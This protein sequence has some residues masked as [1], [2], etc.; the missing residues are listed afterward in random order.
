MRENFPNFVKD[1]DTQVQEVHKVPIMIDAERPAPK[2]IIKMSKVKD[3]E[4][5]LKTAR[6]KKLVT[7]WLPD[8]RGVRENG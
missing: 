6:E 5:I 8:G 3:K 1:I 2:H 4:K 7:R